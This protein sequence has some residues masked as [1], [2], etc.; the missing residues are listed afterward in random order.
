[1][2][3]K[4]K[5]VKRIALIFMAFMMALGLFTVI[6][7]SASASTNRAG[8]YTISGTYDIGNG[9]VTGYMSDFRIAVSTELFKDDASVSTFYNDKVFDW[10]Y[11]SFYI[12]AGDI[13][14]H[15]SFKLTR[16]GSSYASYTLSGK[17]DMYLYQGKLPDGNYVLTY[18]GT[19]WANVMSKKT[20]T[21]TY[22]FRID[23]TAPS[24]SLTSDGLYISSGSY[25]NED[26]KFSASDTYSTCKIYY[27]SPGASS[28]S[29][30]TASSKSVSATSANNGRWYFY[31]TDGY[32]SS[33][34]YSVYLDT[35]APTG[36]ITNSGGT[37]ISSGGYTNLPIKFTATDTGGID[38]LQ[39][40]TPTSSS[41][42]EYSSGT[43]LSGSNGRYYFRAVDNAYNFLDDYS[44]Y[45]DATKPYGTLYGGDT[46]RVS[47]V[48]TN[49]AYV[50]Y[51]AS[52]A[53]S[54]VASVYVKK[55]G[56]NS[57]VSYTGGTKLTAEG[58]Y[59]F[60][61]TDKC[62]NTSETVNITLDRTIPTAQLYADGVKIGDGSYT[63]GEYISFVSNGTCYVKLPDSKSFISYVSGTEFNRAGKYVFYAV[64]EA[65]NSTGEYSVI[66]DRTEKSATLTNISDGK[67]DGDVTVEWS[68]GNSEN[69]APIVSVTVNGV[70]VNN[71]DIIHTVATG[72]YAVRV[73]DAAGNIWSTEFVSSKRNILNDTVKKE[74]FETADA[75]GNIY[76]FESYDNALGF[77]VERENS[78][79]SRGTWN[80]SVWDIGIPMD[81]EDSA[82][83][84][85]GEYFIYKKSGSSDERVA[86]FTLERLGKV[87][88]EYAEASVRCYYY[89]QK[90]PAQ[91]YEGEVLYS[92]G[93]IDK[94]IL[95]GDNIGVTVDGEPFTGNVIEI[96][97]AHTVT[98]FDAFG[99]TCDYTV[100]VVRS[101]PSIFYS[102]SGVTENQASLDR[103]Y[104]FKN[105][106]AVSIADSTDRY[107]MFRVL[108]DRGDVLFVKSLG[109]SVTLKDSGS[110]TVIAVNHAGESQ[111]FKLVISRNA[112]SIEMNADIEEKRL[113]I[114]VTPSTDRES[115][116]QSIE[117]LRSGDG[118]NSWQT[119]TEDDCGVSVGTDRRVYE[120]RRSGLYKVSLTDEFRTGIDAV[121]MTLDYTQ[122]AP[123]GTLD[124]VQN[125]GYTSGR[126]TFKWSDEAVA[127]VKRNGES[128]EYRSG[129]ILNEDGEYLI[130][131]ED[132]DGNRTEYRFVI[133]TIP[134]EISTVGVKGGETVKTP[135]SVCFDEE[136]LCGVIV[137]N[138]VETPYLSGM[139]ITEH[140]KY[141]VKV[142]DKAG[143]V[144]EVSFEID[145]SVD[146][147]ASVHNG[148]I[149][150]SV[151]I[152]PEE[153][154]TVTLIKDGAE[155]EY[156]QGSAIAEAGKYTAILTD[157]YGNTEELSFTVVGAIVGKLTH[158]FDAVEGFE[159]VLVN[160]SEKRLNYGTLEL[161]ESGEYEVTVVAKGVEHKFSL[162]IDATAPS[163]K[164]GGVENGG[165][166][167]GSVTVT[168]LSDDATM[169]VYLDGKLIDYTLGDKL[170]DTGEYKILLVD[171]AGNTGEYSFEI[172]WKMSA[173][174][175]VLIVVGVLGVAGAIVGI[176][177]AGKRKRQYLS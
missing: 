88:S 25:T 136:G 173:S 129:D 83:A 120:F 38:Y 153:K 20:Y 151:T 56:S 121:V 29:Y 165:T 80:G 42:A 93:I 49:A 32:Q 70:S 27:K 44:V 79:V 39:V 36:N 126:V 142:S 24:V 96:E 85:N 103:T 72:E 141:T 167:K 171:K 57:Y 119:L 40:L 128:I 2:I 78:Y 106:V 127:D 46:S 92:E 15:S 115:N 45:Y 22:R 18:V 7:L 67:T 28:Y 117:I 163:I 19:Y 94:N 125:G 111:G 52:D 110:Y 108:D 122:P 150:T 132:L 55:P 164:L 64:D 161:F 71:R 160:G 51:V 134:P 91:P 123:I 8:V 62:G 54:G 145:T 109:E 100:T 50:K 97:G 77:A 146:Y 138:G 65:G 135:V 48:Y 130:I 159:R 166:T 112:P 133:D 59:Y 30:T 155:I 13:A 3:R 37:A 43:E 10:T 148:G 169:E 76:S 140:G 5:A 89:W 131:F 87:I 114:T 147:T 118:G 116:I 154:A 81:T 175:I 26:I 102:V 63:N 99:N 53:D 60:Y 152:A 74:Y 162:T 58:K 104:Y 75:D 11:I 12:H 4:T 168:E 144:S 66:I 61:C 139:Q 35:V 16:N 73:T 41:W 82:N 158:N 69:Y 84:K 1:M 176:I 105:S 14:E 17:E 137:K 174:V 101:T 107:A 33:S 21:F 177:I 113:L 23:T 98:V 172:Q 68:D 90:S 31:A 156:S 9:S 149:S 143:N 6:P 157:K 95:L 170:E 34:T 47:G 124:G 86:Y